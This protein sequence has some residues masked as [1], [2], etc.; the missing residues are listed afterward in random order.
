[1]K[2]EQKCLSCL[3]TSHPIMSIPDSQADHYVSSWRQF[4]GGQRLDATSHLSLLLP[5]R[6]KPK[7]VSL[8]SLLFFPLLSSPL[9]SSPLPITNQSSLTKRTFKPSLGPL[10]LPDGQGWVLVVVCHPTLIN[11][12]GEGKGARS[13]HSLPH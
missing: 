7:K 3:S 6:C 13:P 2:K 4:R 5:L 10:V 12:V 11:R 1:M 9:F 8:F